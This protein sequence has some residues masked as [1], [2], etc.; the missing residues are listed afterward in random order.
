[1][2][3]K[4]KQ[5]EIEKYFNDS[6]EYYKKIFNYEEKSNASLLILNRNKAKKL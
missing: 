3:S 1:M 2:I 4:V 6:K 5:K